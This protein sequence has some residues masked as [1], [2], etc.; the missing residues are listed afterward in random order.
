MQKQNRLRVIKV[1]RFLNTKKIYRIK[2]SS[3]GQTPKDIFIVK[4]RKP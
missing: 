3:F 2:A 1:S 4:F